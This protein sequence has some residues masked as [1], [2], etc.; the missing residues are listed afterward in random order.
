MYFLKDTYWKFEN[1][2]F[3]KAV[4]VGNQLSDNEE[5]ILKN[6]LGSKKSCSWIS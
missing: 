6:A 5:E 2:F 3:Q 4:Y 1:T